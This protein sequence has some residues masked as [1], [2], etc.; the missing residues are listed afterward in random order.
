MSTAYYHTTAPTLPITMASKPSA[1][2]YHYPTAHR[3][4]A[5]PPEA[6]DASTTTSSTMLHSALPSN[7][8]NSNSATSSSYA[9]SSA[10]DLDGGSGGVDLMELLNDR[11]TT[12]AFDPLPLDRG[13]ATQ[14]QT[15]GALNAKHRELLALQQQA[16][17]RMAASRANFADGVKAAKEVK[18]DLEWTGKR[19]SAM[20]S[21]AAKNH[22]VEYNVARVR[23]PSPIDC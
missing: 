7:Y 23:Y 14:A 15:S 9:G 18:R 2:A 1:S 13:I 12:G 22:T 11:L 5:S 3:H 10:S 17:T 20:K 4:A 19:V 6:S 16:R 21:K 8:T